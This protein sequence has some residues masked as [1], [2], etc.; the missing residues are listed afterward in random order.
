MTDIELMFR[1]IE[2]Q[3]ADYRAAVA[4]YAEFMEGWRDRT[5]PARKRIQ[6]FRRASKD[7]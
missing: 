1:Q 7:A 6:R 2:D 3:L 5:D 4:S